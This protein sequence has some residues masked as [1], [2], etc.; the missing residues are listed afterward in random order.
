M[1]GGR[2]IVLVERI[3]QP[4]DTICNDALAR[5]RIT[6]RPEQE[7]ILRAARQKTSR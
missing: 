7:S 3:I 2:R 4:D 1:S 5:E 6:R